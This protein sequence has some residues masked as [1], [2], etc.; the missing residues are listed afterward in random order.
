MNVKY[1]IGKVG[2]IISVWWPMGT[3][4]TGVITT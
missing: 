3:R 1:T 4:F 2:G